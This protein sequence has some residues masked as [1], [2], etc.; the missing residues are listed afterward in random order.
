MWFESWDALARTLAVGTASYVALVM[1]LRVSGKRT[2]SK[3][4]AF[5]FI[6]TIALGSAFATALLSKQTTFAQAATGFALL[7]GL[8]LVVTW[9]SVRLGWM[10]RLVKASPVYLL[11]DGHVDTAALRRARVTLTELR[12]AVRGR[13]LANL[14][15]VAA[16]VLET[17]GSFS[18]IE[19]IDAPASALADVAGEGARPY[20]ESTSG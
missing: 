8:Q 7:V 15:D 10:D 14:E 2:L 5:D 6:V 13:G 3:W 20:R 11:R 16:V 18:V 1:L 12:A 19:S 17:D 4:N 9:L